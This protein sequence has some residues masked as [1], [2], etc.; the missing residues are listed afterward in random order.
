MEARRVLAAPIVESIEINTLA[1]DPADLPGGPQPTSWIQQRSQ[2]SDMRIEFSERINATANDFLLVN[3]GVNAPLDPNTQIFL[4]DSNVE[5]SEHIVSLY[6]ADLELADGVYQLIVQPSLT[7][8]AGDPLDGD[9]DG[10][11]GDPFVYRGSAANQFY[12]L[13]GEW[14]GD[15]GV[16]VFDFA[17]FAYWF[18]K[19]TPQAPTYA[20]LNADGGVSVFD[21]PPFAG[22]FGTAITF[23]VAADVEPP[24]ITV[25]GDAALITRDNVT[26]SGQVID[27]GAGVESLL[28]QV[29]LGSVSSL[30]LDAAGL[31]SFTT[32]LPI[33]GRA[34]GQHL[35]RFRA[36]DYAGNV[37]SL[38][39]ISWQL[40]TA[41]PTVSS[42]ADGLLYEQPTSSRSASARPWRLPPSRP[43]ATR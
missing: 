8:S 22:N 42:S 35:I 16:S 4:G 32:S 25:Q 30:A 17:T 14:N 2:I 27:R 6:L 40:D 41:P 26:L 34:D 23:P 10:I 29:D 15:R 43:A 5:I 7:N 33:D 37:S 28:A 39:T 36:T 31:F 24:E 19:A 1:V 13:A 38:T 18:G 9:G 20:D 21:M 3:L 12:I 11:G